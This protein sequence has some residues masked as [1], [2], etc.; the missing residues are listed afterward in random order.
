MKKFITIVSIIC[1]MLFT[2]CTDGS[3]TMDN[4][5]DTNG[6][7]GEPGVTENK[8]SDM[9]NDA[10]KA[11]NDVADGAANAVRDGADGAMDAVKDGADGAMDAVKDGADGVKRAVED[12]T[13]R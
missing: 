7:Q 1:L 5:H 13:G 12:M 4:G 9:L 8:G 6:M 10:G 2:G 11:V 3:T